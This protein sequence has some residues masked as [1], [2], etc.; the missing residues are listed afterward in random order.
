VTQLPWTRVKKRKFFIGPRE[1]YK[2]SIDHCGR[3]E[4]SGLDTI[5]FIIDSRDMRKLKFLVDTV[6][7]ILV[8]SSSSLTPGV[9]YQLYV[10][11]YIKGISNTITHTGGTI[12]FKLFTD[13]HETTH[14]HV[15][16]ENAVVCCNL[17]GGVISYCSRQIITNDEM[18]L[19]SDP[20]L[21]KENKTL[22]TNVYREQKI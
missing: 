11:F 8:I 6:D 21:S 17:R 19:K 2:F 10:G 16:G 12:D 13:T 9:E 14:S 15:L 18:V 4:S 7:E 3:R 5:F 1:R 22:E 20:K